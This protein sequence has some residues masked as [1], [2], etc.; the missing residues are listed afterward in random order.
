V[1]NPDVAQFCGNCSRPLPRYYK[2]N[3]TKPTVPPPP[4]DA[5]LVFP[6]IWGTFKIT[7]GEF[8]IASVFV[9]IIAIIGLI[10]SLMMTNL[11]ILVFALFPALFLIVYWIRGRIGAST[12]YGD[13]DSSAFPLIGYWFRRRK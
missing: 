11:I 9:I 12:Y 8:T 3:T 5:Y 6:S 13:I 4:P 7:M 2:E 1:E 10:L